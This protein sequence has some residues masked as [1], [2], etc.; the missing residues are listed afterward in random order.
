G[1]PLEEDYT[2][3]FITQT[4]TYSDTDII[5]GLNNPTVIDFAADG[6]V[7]VAEKSGIIKVYDNLGDT[8][9]TIFADLRTNVHNYWDRGLLGLAVHPDYPVTPEVFVLYT[10]D[11]PLSG[12]VAAPAWGS[13]GGTD[14]PGPA[15]TGNPSSVSGRLS[16]LVENGSGVWDGVE[17]VLVEDWG[18]QY[19]SHSIGSIVFGA[20]G[21]LY[22]SGGDGAS[23]NFADYGQNDQLL[24]DNPA[25]GDTRLLDPV[26]EGGALRSLDLRTSPEDPTVDPVSLDGKII[27][28]DP[29]TGN[30]LPDNPLYDA[31][32]ANDDPNA[33]RIVADGLRN[34]FRFTV[35]PGTNELWIGDVGWGQ[36]EEIN[37]L[38][39]PTDTQIDTFGWPA[40]E[41]PNRQ[42]S[43]DALDKSLLEDYYD[44]VDVDPS[45]HVQPFFAY[46]HG[47]PVAP[48]DP[49]PNGNSSS[50]SGVAFSEGGALSGPYGGALFFSDY[51]RDG[52]WVMFPGLDGE[53]DPASR[54]NVLDNAL[55]PTQLTIGPGGDLFYVNLDF[56][57]PNN[58]QVRRIRFDGVDKPP[59]AV[60]SANPTFGPLDQNGELVVNFDGTASFDPNPAD[61]LTYAWDLD[62]DGQFDDSTQAQPTFAFTTSGLHTVTLEVTDSTSLKDTATVIISVDNTL[63]TA[64][65]DTPLASLTWQVGDPITFAGHADDPDEPGGTLSASYL[66]WQI[67]LHHGSAQSS[68]TH[69]ITSFAGTAGDSFTAPDHEYPSHLEIKLTA[70]DPVTGLQ[71]TD[72]VLLFPQT[73]DVTLASNPAG[74][75]LAVNGITDTSPFSTTVIVGSNNSI[76]APSPQLLGQTTYEFTSWSDG[77]G[78]S[79]NFTA[80]AAPQT[81]TAGFGIDFGLDNTSVAENSP[82]G[83]LVGTLAPTLGTPSLSYALVSGSGD[84]D[85]GLFT[86]SGDQLQTAAVLDH[87]AQATYSVRVQSDDG[88]G[89]ALENVFSI[90]ATDVNDAPAASHDTDAIAEE[91]ATPAIGN[92]LP[93]DDDQDGDT[94]SIA[95]IDGESNPANDVTGSYGTL[96]WDTNGNYEYTLDNTNAAVQALTF[97]QTLSEIFNYTVE[98]GNGGTATASLTITID[99]RDDPHLRTGVATGL[100]NTGWT[101]VTLDRSF[102]S[103]VVVTTLNYDSTS[104]PLVPRI[105]NAVGNSFQVR[106]DRTDGLADLVSPVQAHYIVVEEGAYTLAQH[107]IEMEAQ[108][109]ISTV[110]DNRASWVGEQAIY[111]NTYGSPVVFGQVMTYADPNFSTFWSRGSNR[112]SPPSSSTIFVGKHTGEDIT[113]RGSELIGL[114]VLENGTG[115]IDGLDYAAAVG[116]DSI[117]GVGQSP[118]YA[119][120]ISGSPTTAIASQV[121]MDGNDGGWAILYGDDPVSPGALNLAI[122]EDQAND[123]ERNHTTEQVAYL[124]LTGTNQ[125]P[126]NQVPGLQNMDEDTSLVFSAANSNAVTISDPDAGTNP[127]QFTIVADAGSLTLNGTAG[128]TFSNG[129]GT[130][131]GSM[132]FTGT[133]TDI[134][135]ALDGLA[136]TPP[137]NSFGTFSVT[138]L[139]DDQGHTGAGGARSDFDQIDIVVNPVNDPPVN[140]IP[141]PQFTDEDT[142]LVF[143]SGNGNLISVSD[144]DVG[145]NPLLISLTAGNGTFSLSTITGLT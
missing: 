64:V 44:D 62:D 110:T 30:P 118:P 53:P 14:D 106:A 7:F 39:N 72:S 11:A 86:I 55:N 132:I 107:G 20:D 60:A 19:P 117:R 57:N 61:T 42:G 50:I 4:P 74:L 113:A 127:V 124:S 1:D 13:P 69:L 104:P 21:A 79:H 94:L 27:R 126:Q 130:D 67:I 97:G 131:D 95:E 38:R 75:E 81:L 103:M 10:Y 6:T 23:F 35:R 63:P 116:S 77:G 133:M 119:Y 68:H 123:A 40:Y 93:N 108:K 12:S 84:D 49:N 28:I 5:T 46:E 96:A 137:S 138:I 134:N 109:L 90:S 36:W 48:N 92:V 29:S 56:N 8:T 140:A 3:Y 37:V 9:P 22:A 85:N 71:A 33:E 88:S 83:T 65:I 43:Y 141:T 91:T 17:H 143:F 111:I 99:G 15:T 114:V 80:G 45:L 129:D 121:A 89:N 25:L 115:T 54:A 82:L 122:D 26:D 66:D 142:S 136:F 112:N 59:T 58:G 102:T 73:V 139:T 76:S 31:Y 120:T 70:T 100:T 135:T 16:R 51:S 47:E 87:E 18:Q 52:V 2:W 98:D 41:G 101:T 128:L 105:Q 144:V 24:D 145:A 32:G 125:P 34:P 78:Q